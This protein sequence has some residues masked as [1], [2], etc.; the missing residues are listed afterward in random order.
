LTNSPNQKHSNK[1]ENTG[2]RVPTIGDEYRLNDGKTNVD[3]F[4]TSTN[5]VIEFHGDYF[6]GNPAT[7]DPRQTRKGRAKILKTTMTGMDATGC[8]YPGK[9]CVRKMLMA[10]VGQR[11]I[12]SAEASHQL[13]STPMTCSSEHMRL[14]HAFT[15]LQALETIT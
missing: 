10:V 14:V 1:P 5:T 6:H 2:E 12:S 8:D 7:T 9:R 3:G 13:F 4:I 15:D 11:D